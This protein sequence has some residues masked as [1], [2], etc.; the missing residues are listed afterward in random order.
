LDYWGYT[1]NSFEAYN[2]SIYIGGTDVTSSS[3]TYG[4]TKRDAAT[5][6]K[7]Y[8]NAVQNARSNSTGTGK[9]YAVYISNTTATTFEMNYNDY[10][11]DGTGGV[12]GYYSGDVA[13]LAAWQTA[14]GQDA[15]SISGDPGFI[16]NDDLHIKPFINTLDGQGLYFA[17]VP[18]DIDGD[19]RNATT[20]DIGADE[21]TYTP[22]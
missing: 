21:Y 6:Y 16:G 3:T 14:S 19:T 11:A 15:N 22:P 2:N 4:L 12:F 17:S 9:H 5:T 1:A 8:D 13:D 10:Y 20:P 7:A 18:D